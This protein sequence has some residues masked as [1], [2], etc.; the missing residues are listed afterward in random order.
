MAPGVRLTISLE[1]QL[2]KNEKK[3][4]K[5]NSRTL[6]TSTNVQYVNCVI[7]LK[8]GIENNNQCYFVSYVVGTLIV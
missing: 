6:T 2:A 8:N 3:N 5:A 4:I 1:S 7:E